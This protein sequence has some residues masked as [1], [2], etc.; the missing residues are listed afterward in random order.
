M[1]TLAVKG[2]KKNCGASFFREFCEIFYNGFLTEHLRVT[3]S[4]HFSRVSLIYQKLGVPHG[5]FEK[6]YKIPRK[7]PLDG[8]LFGCFR[9]AVLL[10][11]E[12]VPSVLF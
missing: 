3:S 4:V 6:L 10:Q 7:A 11:K 1:G 2:L 8:I 9:P 12:P 5:C